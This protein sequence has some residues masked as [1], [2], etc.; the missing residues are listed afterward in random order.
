MQ[1]PKEFTT[2]TTMSKL[3]ALVVFITFPLFG[4]LLGIGYQKMLGRGVDQIPEPTT[5]SQE[6]GCTLEAKIC[7]DGTA[8]G[9]SG[10]SCEFAPCPGGN[11]E[12][13]QNI[14]ELGGCHIG[15]CSGQLCTDRE[16]VNTTCEYLPEYA[17]YGN[18]VCDRQSNGLCGW[19][20]TSELAACLQ[21][22]S[23]Q[24]NPG[25]L[26]SNESSC[27]D[28]YGGMAEASCKTVPPEGRACSTDADCS[29]SCSRGCI[30]IN[31]TPTTRIMDCMAEPMY[32]CACINNTCKKS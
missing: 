29:A 1:L 2:V 11:I 26:D 5:I 20:Q 30:N 31:W 18:A 3:L 32:S 13:T 7:P 14:R 23:E 17:C 12:P 10:P 16:D 25:V 19:T 6:I 4:F 15:G 22:P 28:I 27:I 9:R 21:K 24:S 8:V